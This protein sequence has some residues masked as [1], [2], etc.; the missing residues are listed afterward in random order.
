MCNDLDIS[1][2]LGAPVTLL[3]SNIECC[4]PSLHNRKAE[5]PIGMLFLFFCDTSGV[6]DV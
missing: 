2:I 6:T 1:V 5:S 3:S 4:E